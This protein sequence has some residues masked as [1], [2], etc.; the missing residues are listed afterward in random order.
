V[1]SRDAWPSTCLPSP[2]QTTFAADER[3]AHAPWPTPPG[4]RSLRPRL[5]P[6][7]AIS[8]SDWCGG[9]AGGR[10]ARRSSSRQRGWRSS[11]RQRWTPQVR[12]RLRGPQGE[13][14]RVRHERGG[15]CGLTTTGAV[16]G[17]V[18]GGGVG[19]GVGA[20]D[21]MVE[22]AEV[23]ARVAGLGASLGVVLE[24]LAAG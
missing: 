22:D 12:P 11:S 7:P 20:G 17:W 14:E 21:G 5:A 13:R 1:S 23:M 2:T 18:C 16:C 8:P 6:A 4:P 9:G 10:S 3:A 19:V 15:L 24:R